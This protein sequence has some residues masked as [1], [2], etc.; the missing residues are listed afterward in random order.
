MAKQPSLKTISAGYYSTDQLN[1]NFSNIQNAFDNTLSRDGSTPNTMGADI[2]LNQNDL[3]NVRDVRTDN[4]YINGALVTI[5]SLD[6]S[7]ADVRVDDF[8]GDGSTVDFTLA[9]DPENKQAVLVFVDGISQDV[10]TYSISGTTLTFTTAPPNNSNIECRSFFDPTTPSDL[11]LK[12]DI[13]RLTWAEQQVAKEL[14]SKFVTYYLKSDVEDKGNAA[15]K[16]I[17]VIAQEVVR[18]FELYGL[19]VHDY[20]II[21]RN[22]FYDENNVYTFYYS[23]KYTSLLAFVIAGL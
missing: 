12:Q 5:S 21:R 3:L 18:L 8:T 13:K 1:N 22:Y 6:A 19:D 11:R 14:K 23:V 20:D 4:L 16:K 2:D 17:G 10:D 7:P 9:N 15:K